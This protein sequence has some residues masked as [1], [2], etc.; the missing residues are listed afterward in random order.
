LKKLDYYTEDINN[1][2]IS[3]LKRIAEYFYRE[4]LLSI[5]ERDYLNRIKCP[6][7]DRWF[8]EDKIQVAHFRDRN[9]I[10]TAFDLD[11]TY[12]ISEESNVWDSKIKKDG[13][14]SLHHYEYEMWLR[15]FKSEKIMKK[16][17]DN[18]RNYTIFVRDIY[19]KVINEYRK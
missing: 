3:E 13:Y 17:L 7:K 9:Y 14:K 8:K 10:E 6:L 16:L 1:L 18:K 5:C 12:L 2:K 11:N 19:K 4:H 15:T